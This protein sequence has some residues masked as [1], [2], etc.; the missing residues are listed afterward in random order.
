[1]TYSAYSDVLQIALASITKEDFTA[2]PST[3][4]AEVMDEWTRPSDHCG[5]VAEVMI[6]D[7]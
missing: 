6:N 7:Q 5:L 3:P 2:L 4:A 1:M